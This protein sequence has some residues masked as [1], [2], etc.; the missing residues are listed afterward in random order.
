VARGTLA[1]TVL[2]GIGWV[3]VDT[4]ADRDRAE[5]RMAGMMA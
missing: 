3:D 1:A 4:P 5:Q 2:A